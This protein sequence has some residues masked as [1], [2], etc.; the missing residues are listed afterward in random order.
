MDKR[1]KNDPRCHLELFL[2]WDKTQYWM[3]LREGTI[4]VEWTRWPV[5]IAEALDHLFGQIEERLRL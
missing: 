5:G 4:S 3:L 2:S 1:P